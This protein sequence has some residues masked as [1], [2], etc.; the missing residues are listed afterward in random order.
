MEC[1]NRVRREEVT[2]GNSSQGGR[3]V[4]EDLEC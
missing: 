1:R 4:N 3:K 2:G